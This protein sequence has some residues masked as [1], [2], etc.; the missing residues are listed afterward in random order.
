MKSILCTRTLNANLTR[1]LLSYIHKERER[2][3]KGPTK[4]ATELIPKKAIFRALNSNLRN[5]LSS[6]EVICNLF[7]RTDSVI[8]IRAY[9]F[10]FNQVPIGGIGIRSAIEWK[11][12]IFSPTWMTSSARS[13]QRWALGWRWSPSG[14]PQ[15][16]SLLGTGLVSLIFSTPLSDLLLSERQRAFDFVGF[17]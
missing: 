3:N 17:S 14:M 12:E 4:P 15:G 13:L 7:N 16:L 1:E 6:T 10:N 2:L 11:E 9:W 8:K 5:Q